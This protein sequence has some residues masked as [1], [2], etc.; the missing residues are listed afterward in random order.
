MMY[1]GL[2]FTRSETIEWYQE[3]VSSYAKFRYTKSKKPIPVKHSRTNMGYTEDGKAIAVLHG[4]VYTAQ[5]PK[6]DK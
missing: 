1:Q 2:N 3:G 5:L 4:L 6:G